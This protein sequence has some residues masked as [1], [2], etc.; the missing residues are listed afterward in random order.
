MADAEWE[1]GEGKRRREKE[2]QKR[3]LITQIGGGIGMRC[4][5]P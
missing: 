3:G 4:G 2:R 5:I 1:E